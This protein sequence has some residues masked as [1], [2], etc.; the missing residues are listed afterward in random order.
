M[1]EQFNQLWELVEVMKTKKLADEFPADVEEQ[2]ERLEEGVQLY[3]K[4][5]TQ[6]F[7]AAGVTEE[8]LQAMQKNFLPSN[9]QEA[10]MLE[11]AKKLRKTV[12][13]MGRSYE[14]AYHIAK[15]REEIYG[16]KQGAK[17]IAKARKKKFKRL[18]GDKD[19]VPL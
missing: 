6:A 18:G 2:L 11:R 13:E 8:N 17:N 9:P 15:R 19:W 16:K 3:K 12:E 14:I 1:L 10:L 5:N 4:L 7:N